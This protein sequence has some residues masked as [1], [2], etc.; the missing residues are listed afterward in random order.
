MRFGCCSNLVAAQKD[1]VG[2]EVIGLA[3]E[4]GY[5]YIEMPLTS[6][7]ALTEAEYLHLKKTILNSGIK[8]EACNNFFPV[9]M[10]LTGS[11]VHFNEVENYL[12][13]AF[14]RAS[15]LGTKSI[16]FGSGPSKYVPKGFPMDKA[17][18]QS[19]DLLRFIDELAKP[20]D[21]TIVL[22]PLRKFEC[23]IVNTLGEGLKLAKVVDRDNIKCLVDLY[24]MDAE[25]EDSTV[26]LE[27]KGYLRHIHFAMPKGRVYPKDMNEYNYKPF[28]DNLKKIDYQHRISIE[29]LSDNFAEDAKISLKFLKN[30]FKEGGK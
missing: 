24:H 6:I 23:N 25:N 20:Y 13:K 26:I 8:C 4:I 1:A 14:D 27:A 21:I 16:V 30:S 2:I 28:I 17:W 18:Q 7:M 15:Q 3:K 22:E 5:D 9:N 19:V 29:A 11:E 12:R 10:R